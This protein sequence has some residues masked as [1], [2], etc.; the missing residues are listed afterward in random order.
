MKNTFSLVRIHLNPGPSNPLLICE[1]ISKRRKPTVPIFNI[2][3]IIE[4]V[5]A[6]YLKIMKTVICI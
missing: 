6:V 4:T 3:C 1:E 5:V 2:N